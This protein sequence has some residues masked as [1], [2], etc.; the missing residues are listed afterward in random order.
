MKNMDVK[1]L[2][3][4]IDH[5]ML[6]PDCSPEIFKDFCLKAMEYKFECVAILPNMVKNAKDI[7]GG[8][9]VKICA[10]IGFPEGIIPIQLKM[11]EI[12]D[13]IQNGCQEL[14]MVIN[15]AEVKFHNYKFLE[16]EIKEFRTNTKSYTAKII[17][18]ASI[19]TK[20]EISDLTK[21]SCENEIDYI[22][23]STGF[24][25]KVATIE[26]V[27]TIKSNIFGKTKIKA[28]GGIK[29]LQNAL[30][31]IEA[32]ASRLGTSNGVKIVNEF[33]KN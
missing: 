8:T 5:T 16:K 13:A 7:L 27:K 2:R 15:L 25:G 3:K 11:I 20:E 6:K 18:E 29:N 24:K 1:K 12:E 14:D 22:K 17:I 26:D 28:A 33:L 9:D 31:M 30:E 23:T 32:G 19:L 21:I 4:M 10:A